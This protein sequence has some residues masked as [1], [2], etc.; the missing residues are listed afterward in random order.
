MKIFLRLPGEGEAG[1]VCNVCMTIF[2]VTI[3]DI[4]NYLEVFL[5]LEVGEAIKK[6]TKD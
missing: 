4:L 3:N 2:P 5:W 6:F 1:Y